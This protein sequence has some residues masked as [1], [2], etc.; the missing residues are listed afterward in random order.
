MSFPWQ[1]YLALAQALGNA[2][3]GDDLRE[4]KYRSAISRA[5]YAAYH[6]ALQYYQQTYRRRPPAVR[7]GGVHKALC[8]ALI[9]STTPSEQLGGGS[10]EE[11]KANRHDADYDADAAVGDGLVALS[12][13]L[14]ADVMD[15]LR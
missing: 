1:D 6:H 12:L 10:L 15:Q 14:A 13:H 3:R 5:Y 4:A 9:A 8:D 7:D 2:P 11:L